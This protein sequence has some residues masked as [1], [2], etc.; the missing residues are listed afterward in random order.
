MI[1]LLIVLQVLDLISTMVALRNPK[2]A[3]GNSFGLLQWFMDKIGVLPALVLLKA[4]F[5]GWL[6]YFRDH[7]DMTDQV[8]VLLCAGYAWIVVNNIRLIRKY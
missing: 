8:Y 3:E 1:Y 5:I 7:P 6:W 4:A 2:L